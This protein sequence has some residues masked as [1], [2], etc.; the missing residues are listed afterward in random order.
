MKSTSLPGCIKQ[1]PIDCFRR[2]IEQALHMN[3]LRQKNL[4]GSHQTQR[5]AFS[6]RQYA[7]PDAVIAAIQ[8]LAGFLEEDRDEL[9]SFSVISRHQKA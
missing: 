4:V 9:A 2:L 6:R 7:A 5:P 8:Q 3:R 1:H